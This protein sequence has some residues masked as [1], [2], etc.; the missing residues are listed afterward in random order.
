MSWRGILVILAGCVP[1]LWGQEQAAGPTNE[2][3]QKTFQEAM[4]LEKKHRTFWALEGFKKADKQDGGH[5]VACQVKMVKYGIEL[6]DW[7]TAETAAE[8]LVTQAQGDKATAIAHYQFGRVLLAE[9]I[10][11]KKEELFTRAHGELTNALASYGNFPDAIYSDGRAL[12]RLKQDDAAKA[13]F[14]QFAKMRPDGDVERQ[15]AL[16]FAS[17]PELARARM[18]PAF[19]V[20]TTD[21]QRVSLDDLQGKVVLVD[22]WATWCGACLEALPHM[23]QL[24][25]K[26]EGQPLVLLSVSL[27]SEEQKWKNFIAKNEMFWPQCRDGGFEGSV[28]RMFDV[29]AIPHTFTIDADGVLQDEHIG[30]ASLEGKI[31]KLIARAHELEAAQK[32]A[33]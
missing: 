9:G 16:R 6:R 2:K 12:A 13:R 32:P 28:A 3:A 30:D 10:D 29:H 14:E 1:S 15:R 4:E 7:K 5:C 18:A 21:G 20:T 33:Q 23:K 24:A 26:F 11:K 22:F 31:K 25:K 19:A 8:E 17:L 27:D